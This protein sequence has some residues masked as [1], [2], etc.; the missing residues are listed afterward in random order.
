MGKETGVNNGTQLRG[1]DKPVPYINKIGGWSLEYDRGGTLIRLSLRGGPSLLHWSDYELD[2]GDGRIFHPRGWDECFPTIDAHGKSGV[3]GRLI[4]HEPVL[5]LTSRRV[6]QVWTCPDLTARRTFSSPAED[7]LLIR[8]EAKNTG[9]LPLEFLWASHA[10]FS[11]SGL[12]RVA[13]PHNRVL[14]D[15]SLDHTCDKFFV[16]SSVPVILARE[17]SVVTLS[18][19]QPFWGIWLNRGGWPANSP[20]GFCCL[21][22]EATNSDAEVPQGA[23]LKAGE[24]FRGHAKL[25]VESKR[26]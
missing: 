24:F 13:L 6:S 19:D 23:V 5:R 9:T 16:S 10:L 20:A 11:V 15:F 2:L 7:T 22:I 3:M 8:F 18:T 4:G 14:E 12:L 26:S 21:G 25:K 17:E 1:R